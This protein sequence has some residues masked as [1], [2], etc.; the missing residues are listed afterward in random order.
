MGIASARSVY[1]AAVDD[2]QIVEAARRQVQPVWLSDAGAVSQ[3]HVSRSLLLCRV[4]VGAAER[5]TGY[6]TE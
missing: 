5:Q 3:R 1:L 2:G 4:R 6:R